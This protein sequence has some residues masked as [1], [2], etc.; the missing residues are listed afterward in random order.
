MAELA[1]GGCFVGSDAFLFFAEY[2][3]IDG[4]GVVGLH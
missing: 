2:L 4:S 1:F 3:D